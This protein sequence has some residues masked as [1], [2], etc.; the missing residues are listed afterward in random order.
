MTMHRGWSLHTSLFLLLAT[1]LIVPI[2]AFL[3]NNRL[4]VDKLEAFGIPSSQRHPCNATSRCRKAPKPQLHHTRR[5]HQ[6][7][8]APPRR[9]KVPLTTTL[10]TDEDG[11]PKSFSWQ[12]Y[13][14]MYPDVLELLPGASEE[15]ARLHYYQFGFKEGRLARLPPVVMQYTVCGTSI[16]VHV[17]S[18]LVVAVE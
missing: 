8:Q 14:A 11:I 7:K 10:E 9:H 12:E 15:G 6:S 16:G 5:L 17:F 18:S 13:L 3:N 2:S 1:V 4:V